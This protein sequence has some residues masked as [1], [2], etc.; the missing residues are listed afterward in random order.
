MSAHTFSND[1]GQNF[2]NYLFTGSHESLG[3]SEVSRMA[4]SAMLCGWMFPMGI[5]DDVSAFSLHASQ[6]LMLNSPMVGGNADRLA[7]ED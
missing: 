5:G 1:H 6:D 7:W 3:K 4:E 2:D